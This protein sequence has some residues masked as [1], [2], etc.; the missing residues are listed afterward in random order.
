MNKVSKIFILIL[1]LALPISIF[2]FL[3]EFG[4]N[5]FEIPIYYENG[6]NNS[7][8][9]CSGVSGGQ[10]YAYS[11]KANNAELTTANLFI[12][13]QQDVDLSQNELSNIWS[14]LQDV[15][16]QKSVG[17]VTYTPESNVLNM[18]EGI[19][20]EI[21]S[22]EDFKRKM[23]C[24]AVTDTVNQFILVDKMSRIRGYYDFELEEVDRLI[25]ETK[26]LIEE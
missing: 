16:K 24:D 1:I 20:V 25:V 5:K 11:L 22:E 19:G 26:I 13:Y 7:F 3:K 15:F 2:V 21:L 23:H 9:E 12:F 10:F 17:F 18:S 6:I 4:N 8:D 14:R